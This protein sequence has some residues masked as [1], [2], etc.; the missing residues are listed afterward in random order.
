MANRGDLASTLERIFVPRLGWRSLL[1]EADDDAESEQAAWIGRVGSSARLTSTDSVTRDHVVFWYIVE[2][3]ARQLHILSPDGELVVS[4]GI[5]G[6]GVVEPL[7]ERLQ[8]QHAPVQTRI[9]IEDLNVHSLCRV[10][11]LNENDTLCWV[12]LFVKR[13]WPGAHVELFDVETPDGP[14]VELFRYRKVVEQVRDPA[15]EISLEDARQ[16]DSEVEVNDDLGKP[17]WGEELEARGLR[18]WLIDQDASDLTALYR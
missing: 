15:L 14:A 1:T 17:I 6:D 5:G 2:V 9:P 18:Q 11:G 8:R 7:P 16:L 13:E 10:T 3:A 12:M 4:L